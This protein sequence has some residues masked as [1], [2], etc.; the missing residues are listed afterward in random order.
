[1]KNEVRVKAG[2]KAKRK[3]GSF[4]RRVAKSL[5]EFWGSEFFRTPASGGSRLKKDYNLAGDVCTADDEWFFHIECKNQE[6]LGNFWAFMVS[7][8]NIVWKWWDQA[9]TECPSHQVPVLVFTKN[10][11]PVW[12]ML[13]K[14]LFSKFIKVTGVDRDELLPRIEVQDV[15]VIPFDLFLSFGKEKWIKLNQ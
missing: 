2:K 3:G 9:T 5:S 8:K 11:M 13:K 14:D 6:S 10:R 4:E 7:D 15:I 12:A 1:M